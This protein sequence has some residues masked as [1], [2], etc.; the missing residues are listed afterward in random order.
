MKLYYGIPGKQCEEAEEC[1]FSIADMAVPVLFRGGKEKPCIFACLSPGDVSYDRNTE[2][3]VTLEADMERVYV[4]EG[5]FRREAVLA[6][7]AC[8][9]V[10]KQR[11]EGLYAA[12]FLP[13]KEYAFGHYLRP[14][15]PIPFSFLPG[16]VRRYCADRDFPV[17]CENAEEYYL[18]HT[19]HTLYEQHK[20]FRI[21]AIRQFGD[22]LC[23]ADR[24]EKIEGREHLFYM[25][26]TDT[27]ERNIIVPLL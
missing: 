19:F 14:E 22:T 25:D 7:M 15:C 3:L 1:G 16:T 17:V 9:D 13:A 5:A 12:S 23:T 18:E 11:F 4:A 26:H 27:A 6:A 10:L 20:E 2:V 21:S 24:A 8:D